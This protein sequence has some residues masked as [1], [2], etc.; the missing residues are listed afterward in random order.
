MIAANFLDKTAAESANIFKPSLGDYNDR[1][2]SFN[3]FWESA[4]A[5]F[6]S[7]LFQQRSWE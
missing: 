1:L 6:R 7:D 4:F 2:V 3:L 5:S